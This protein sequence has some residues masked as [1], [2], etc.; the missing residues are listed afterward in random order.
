MG[1][2]KLIKAG[3]KLVISVSIF[4]WT[5]LSCL[6]TKEG[7]D[8][9]VIHL[10]QWTKTTPKE[11]WDLVRQT[12]PQMRSR[13][14]PVIPSSDNSNNNFSRILKE[15][16]LRY[17]SISFHPNN[18]KKRNCMT[19]FLILSLTTKTH[20]CLELF[21]YAYLLSPALILCLINLKLR[22][23]LWKMPEDGLKCSPSLFPKLP[24]YLTFTMSPYLSYMGE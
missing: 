5:I 16:G 1:V 11:Q 8:W 18:P 9:S 2:N 21:N 13:S 7:K 3:E 6:R 15:Q 22:P 17:W 19:I 10:S 24:L 4:L 20:L 14:N 23:V 12:T